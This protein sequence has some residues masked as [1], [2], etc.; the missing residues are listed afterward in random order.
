MI[1]IDVVSG[2]RRQEGMSDRPLD[3]LWTEHLNDW[4][5]S[6]VNVDLIELNVE[7]L[8][9]DEPYDRLFISSKIKRLNTGRLS[10]G[11]MK[12][13]EFARSGGWWCSGIDPLND[14]KPMEWGCFKPDAPR[15]N[16]DNKKIIKYEHPPQSPTRAFFL[17]VTWQVG[18]K[19]ASRHGLKREYQ[20]RIL[21]VRGNRPISDFFTT[22]DPTFWQWVLDRSLPVM[23]VEGAKKA[24]SVLSSGYVAIALPG[25]FNG[26]RVKDSHGNLVPRE[27]IPELKLFATG[28]RHFYI[29]FDHD[30]K[31]KTIRNVNT[32]IR[33]LGTLLQNLRCEVLIVDLPGPEKG[34]DDF[35]IARGVAD[36]HKLVDQALSLSHRKLAQ[37]LRTRLTVQPALKIFQ[38]DLSK[39]EISGIPDHGIVAIASAKGTGK[40]KFISAQ[41]KDSPKAVLA[42]HRIALARNLCDRL[43]LNYRGDID[44]VKGGDFIAGDAFT[45]R[46]GMCVDSVLSVDPNRFTDCDLVIDE[47]CQVVRHLLTSSTCN[48]DG[49][50]PAILARFGAL[51]QQAR[52]VI[53]ADADLDNSTLDYLRALRQDEQP[54]YLIRNDVQLQGYPAMFFEAPDR[55]AIVERLLGEV[56]DMPP[57]KTLYISTDSRTMSKTLYELLANLYPDKPALLVNAQTSG[58]QDEKEF[59]VAPDKVL[60]RDDYSIIIASPSV[61][62]GTSIEIQDKIWK[63]FGIYNGVSGTDADICQALSRVRQPVERII[64]C[65]PTGR[66]F[67]KASRSTNPL[68]LKGHLF[69][70]TSVSV[71]LL[72]SSLKADTLAAT[73]TIDWTSDPHIQLFAQISAAQ[74]F[75]MHNLRDALLVRLQEE[76][77]AVILERSPSISA[78]NCL[79]KTSREAVKLAEAQALVN[80]EDLSS[81]QVSALEK[82]ET[83]SPEEQRAIAKFYLKEFYCLP[84]LTLQDV[85]GDRE[86]R[87]RGELL[88]L[89]AQLYPKLALDK[90]VKSLEQQASWRQSLC[91]WDLP[92]TELRRKIRDQLG[93]TDFIQAGAAGE[94]WIKDDLLSL[95]TH[96]RTYSKAIKAHLNFTITDEMSDVQVVHQLLSQLGI[97][98]DFRWSNL[99]PSYPG[100]KIRVYSFNRS[101]WQTLQSILLRR[102]ETRNRQGQGSMK[103]EGSPISVIPT[104]PM[105]DPSAIA[106]EKAISLPEER[107]TTKFKN[108]E[109]LFLDF[110]SWESELETG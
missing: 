104:S 64:W 83:V 44:R 78:A 45:M 13:Y 26:Y 79:L 38:Q 9:G 23:L 103:E 62:T 65:A 95:A 37:R 77:N 28:G 5:D 76:G 39:L 60:E 2:S 17:R 89:E 88:N 15:I 92:G 82:K 47:V 25:I 91:P 30:T 68:E 12:G 84:E 87:S 53:V 27:L 61:G 40:T 75:A 48:K 14:W 90:T 1:S 63:V 98:I 55:T 54:I 51:I 19:I 56:R 16:P 86:G 67:C 107:K 7:S 102:E 100:K 22:E 49:K 21:R 93:L 34:A 81:A 20:H 105:G 42:S 69:E 66:N 36:F 70:R 6:A 106:P 74:N 32:A 108:L 96:A 46:V 52:R 99:H 31:V 71:S 72:R 8:V 3:D 18:L 85:L 11:W 29:C 57:E 58:G 4:L 50:R 110:P 33:N 97:K 43:G 94:E 80:A 41:V 59:I 109:Q 24:G 35:I 10:H 101:H 73:Q